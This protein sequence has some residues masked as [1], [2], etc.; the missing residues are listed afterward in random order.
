MSFDWREY[1]KLAKHLSGLKGTACS[2]E[3]ID[4]SVVSRA[5][6]SAFCWA[7][8]YAQELLGFRG[9][10]TAEDHR[11]LRNHLKQTGR[12]DVA[13]D[14]NILRRWRNRCDYDDQ[15]D[16]LD[17]KVAKAIAAADKVIQRLPLADGS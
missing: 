17:R 3:A 2:R 16:K 5:Y 11:S 13:A 15:V 4:R 9:K 6:Y 8:N 10:G 12:A 1:L 7:R 14:L